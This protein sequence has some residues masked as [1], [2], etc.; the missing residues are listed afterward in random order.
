MELDMT[1]P[2]TDPNQDLE[3][4]QAYAEYL[5]R[6]FDVDGTGYEPMD[7]PVSSGHSSADTMAQDHHQA[8]RDYHR[9][10]RDAD[11]ATVQAL[12]QD[13]AAFERVEAGQG[14]EAD[15]R[16]A[17]RHGRRNGLIPKRS[18]VDKLIAQGARQRRVAT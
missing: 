8:L 7:A 1:D 14:N 16:A 2:Y 13:R 4:A 18:T 5:R 12:A 9:E 17:H 3:Q 11:L 6:T 10:Q 15:R